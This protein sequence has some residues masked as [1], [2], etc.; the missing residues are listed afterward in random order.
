MLRLAIALS[1]LTGTPVRVENI[2]KNR[3]RP[4]LQA[5]HLASIRLAQHVSASSCEG[6]RI[7]SEEVLFIPQKIH[8]AVAEIDI[9]TAGS[10]PLAMQSIILPAAF[11]S[12]RITARMKGGTDVPYAPSMDYFVNVFARAINHYIA[13]RVDILRRGYYPIGQG[14]ADIHLTSA[15][16]RLDEDTLPALDLASED[17]P[18][19][20]TLRL[21]GERSLARSGM[22]ERIGEYFTLLARG[23]GIDATAEQSYHEAKSP[24]GTATLEVHGSERHTILGESFLLSEQTKPEEIAEAAY[25]RARALLTRR[26]GCDR[27][28]ADQALPFLAV[29]QKGAIRAE[30]ITDHV[31][32]NV[33]VCERFLGPCL[34]IDEEKKMIVPLTDRAHRSSP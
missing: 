26:P 34:R 17:T 32:S 24:G 21:T 8:S 2:R 6:A 12:V 28:L 33:E 27:H 30:E 15:F 18:A 19:K 22:L 31:R 10:I 11:A 7:G 13:M 4:G 14:R 29:L 16:S 1:V 23:L 9:E 25:E 20:A 5:Q 3:D